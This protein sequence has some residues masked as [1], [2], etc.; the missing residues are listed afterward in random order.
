M[1]RI[2]LTVGPSLLHK[3]PIRNFHQSNY[4]YRINGAHGSIGHIRDDLKEIRKQVPK[5]EILIDLPGNKVRTANLKHSIHLD[6]SKQFSLSN[7][8]TNYPGFYAHLKKGDVVW[9]NDSIFKFTVK[10]A[11]KR[12]VIFTSHSK[13]ILHNNKGLHVRG[14]HGAIPFLFQKDKELIKLANRHEVSHVGLSFVRNINDIKMA[15]ALISKGVQV[16]SKVETKEAVRNVDSILKIVDYILVDR[17]D[18]STEIGLEKV[19]AYQKYIV[20][21]ALFYNKKV[22]LA[23]QFLKTMETNP[24]PTIAEVVDLYNTFKMGVYGIQL[25]E[26]TAIGAHVD[27][28]LSTLHGMLREIIHELKS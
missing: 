4:I 2:I 14:I 17:G 25:S 28:C 16:I 22:F 10:Q 7:D 15:K 21:R 24:I 11:S 27:K 3:F 1:K 20:D 19:P 5:A 8:E 12:E 18:L 23:T 13:G 26:E 9:A 6:V